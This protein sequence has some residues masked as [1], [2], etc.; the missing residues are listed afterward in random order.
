ML[1]S[2]QR[3]AVGILAAIASL[4]AVTGTAAAA[5]PQEVRLLMDWF[6]QAD[7]GGY[8][9]AQIE[10]TGA[11]YGI[12][13]VVRPGGP[14]IQTIPQ[15]AAG[16]AEFGIGNADDLLL[17]RRRGA[18]VRAVFASLNYVPYTLVYHPSPAIKT[19][20]DLKGKT[21]AVS[22]G[23]AYWEWVKKQYGLEGVRQIPVSG[24]LTLFKTN[25]NLVQQGYSLFL[26][27]RMNAMG[28]PNA[29]FTVASLGYRPYDVLFTTDAMIKEH[30]KLVRATLAAVKKGWADFIADPA[31]TKAL[32]LKRN[33][34]FTPAVQNSAVKEMF[35]DMLPHDPAKIGCMKK[36][37]WDELTKQLKEVNFLPADFNPAPAYDL[38]LVPGCGK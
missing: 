31:K 34:Q 19:I 2:A 17:A 7:Q 12:K 15:V 5:P 26:P 23:A 10:Q 30:P 11:P 27:P 13:I 9:Q 29:Q 3:K 20:R 18:P 36:A 28:I 33:H 6:A 4:V 8:W 32:I 37:R 16:Q 35:A 25:A 1:L 21:F 22:L 14:K 24:D 38:N